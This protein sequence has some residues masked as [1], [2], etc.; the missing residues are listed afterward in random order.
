MNKL[1][2]AIAFCLIINGLYAQNDPVLFKIE[3]VPVHVSEFDY[4]YNKN[5]GDG[6][7]YS[8][9]SLEEYLDLYTKFKL[10]VQRAKELQL[11]TIK[12][13]NV[14]LA[15]YRKQLADSYLV[16]KE[17]SNRLVEELFERKKVDRKIAHLLVVVDERAKAMDVATAMQKIEKAKQDLDSGDN[18]DVVVR[19]YSDDKNTSSK[20]GEMGFY[21]AM[22]PKGFYAF[23]NAMYDTEIGKYSDI[24]R[25]KI[26]FHIVKVLE[27]RPSRGEVELAHI[28]TRKVDNEAR[29]TLA[30]MRIDSVYQKLKNGESFDAL[31]KV[32][33]EDGKTKKK[34]GYLGYVGINVYDPVF[35]SAAFGLANDADFSQPVETKVGW[36]IIKRMG[37]RSTTDF[38]RAKG[39]LQNQISNNDRYT[40]ARTSLINSIKDEAGYSEDRSTLDYFTGLLD[41]EFYTFKWISPE[42]Q[43]KELFTF[44][45]QKSKLSDFVSYCKKNTRKRLQF[46]K[47]MPKKDAVDELYLGFVE[48]KALAFE[49]SNLEKKYPEFKALMR[50]YEEG[51]LLF[52]ITK[53]EVWDKASM[54]TTGL[55]QFFNDNRENYKWK[56]RA[57][58]YEYTIN[59][60]DKNVV[61]AVYNLASKNSKD[62][63]MDEFNK[64]AKIVK[65]SERTYEKG[66]PNAPKFKW[67]KGK[68]SELKEDKGK[69]SFYHTADIMAPGY[70]KLSES[71]GYIIAD[72]QDKLEKD[73]ISFLKERYKVE[74]M[75]DVFNGL[76]KK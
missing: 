67:S 27:E 26:G 17:V 65:V 23:E 43:D 61:K 21:T 34:G 20:G 57:K 75:D 16:D 64:Q 2:F 4:I 15:G 48:E 71:R 51:I 76:I 3:G 70:K 47:T 24:I 10:K 8:K 38:D 50:E 12:Q 45:T 54:D 66:D 69:T 11:D 6:A 31:A 7:D 46:K 41:D 55:Q 25:S 18:W 35:E 53:Q 14:E 19:K 40:I 44:G 13:L 32:Y 1:C 9:E 62:V 5:N 52:E 37:K 58:V 59:S 39:L 36:H 42:I 30:K 68:S 49:E 56:E 60:K 33:S 74:L 22:L 63:V 29:N 72:Y 73:W 28:L